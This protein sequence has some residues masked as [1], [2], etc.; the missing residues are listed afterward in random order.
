MFK[1][2]QLINYLFL[3]ITF[4]LDFVKSYFSQDI[5][6]IRKISKDKFSSFVQVS[7]PLLSREIFYRFSH[8]ISSDF[9]LL[10]LTIKYFLREGSLFLYFAIILGLTYG[11]TSTIANKKLKSI[12]HN[13]KDKLFLQGFNA[14][15]AYVDGS[16]GLFSVDRDQLHAPICTT[17]KSIK[18]L[19]SQALL[20]TSLPKFASE[21]AL[22][23]A[24]HNSFHIF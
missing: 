13:I 19:Q 20:F 6:S 1:V 22:L 12:G 21:A 11:I 4:Y 16:T 23:I 2:I 8:F 9:L 15:H 24:F 17:D 5:D 18:I 3:A 14:S 10:S 7:F